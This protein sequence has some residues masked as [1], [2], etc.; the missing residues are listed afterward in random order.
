MLYMLTYFGE[1][2]L[3]SMTY[4]DLFKDLIDDHLQG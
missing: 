2:V 4:F 1:F 3:V